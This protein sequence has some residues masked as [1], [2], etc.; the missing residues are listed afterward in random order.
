MWQIGRTPFWLEFRS[1]LSIGGWGGAVR[2]QI[3]ESVHVLPIDFDNACPDLVGRVIL[4]SEDSHLSMELNID[5]IEPLRVAGGVTN[6]GALPVTIHEFCLTIDEI[7]V[8]TPGSRLSFYKHGYQSWSETRPF[9]ADERA[10]RPLIPAMVTMQDNRRNLASGRRGAFTSDMFTLLANLDERRYLLLGQ[11]AH[12]HQFL[13]LRTR[14]PP[15]GRLDPVS[16]ELAWEMEQCLPVGKTVMLD[17]LI[18]MVGEHPNE[19]LESYME[20]IHVPDAREKVSPSGWCSWYYYFTR[21]SQADLE[22][23]LEAAAAQRMDWSTIV[24]DDGYST[25]LGDWLS[26]D[27][28]FPDGLGRVADAIRARGMQPGIWMAPFVAQKSSQIYREHPE[29]FIQGQ[30]RR[31]AGAGW[32][33]NWGLRGFFYGL[34]PTNPAF[35]RYLTRVVKTLVHDFGFCYLKLDFTYGA[36]LIGRAYD[37]TLSP[38]ERLA[39]GHR[40]I[41]E[42]AG[43]DVFILGCGCPMSGAHG[44]VDAM[45]IGPDVAPY[46]FA[47]YRYHLTRDPHA[48]CAKFAIRSILNRCQMHRQLWINDPDCLLLREEETKL[49]REERMALVNAV[50]ITGGMTMISDRLARLAP[51][52]WDTLRRIEDLVRDCDHGRPWPLDLMERQIPELVYNSRGYLAVFNFQEQPV[53]KRVRLKYYLSG[54]LPEAVEWEDVWSGECHQAADGVLDLGIMAPHSSI[55]LRRVGERDGNKN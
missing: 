40:L 2:Y 47:T 24:L 26:I 18:M 14:L 32:N 51:E 1:A 48:L 36:A 29:W 55:L 53:R 31:P 37:P 39:L 4:S 7:F 54:L 28:R 10:M 8:G 46:W 15:T 52:S 17:E 35:Q 38:A 5:T 33:P 13:Y 20:L 11:G 49:S 21:I 16:L 22:E 43:D 6:Q 12:A 41:R 27:A 50:I 42:A 9:F 45:R 3:G 44:L 25:A 34:D 19:L 30:N 23:N